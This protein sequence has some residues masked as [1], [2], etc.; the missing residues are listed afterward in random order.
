[1]KNCWLGK[2]SKCPGVE[3]L[4]AEILNLSEEDG[5]YAILESTL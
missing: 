4:T 5:S 2:C 3:A 1:M